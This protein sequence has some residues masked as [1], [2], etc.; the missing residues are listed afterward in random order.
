M[1][2]KTLTIMFIDVQGYT[3]LTAQKKRHEQQLFVTE[4]RE[5]VEKHVQAK[6]GK[7]TK[8][9]GDGFLVTFESPTD[10]ISCGI[11]LQKEISLR[12]KNVRNSENLISF[13]IGMSTGEVNVDDTGD[14]FGDVVNIAARI[15]KFAEPNEVFISESTYLAM[16]AAEI[17]ALDLGPQ[18]FKN[19]VREV[20]V[21]KVLKDAGQ[22]HSAFVL[23]K[24]KDRQLLNVL[25]VVLAL[26]FIGVLIST[27]GLGRQKQTRAVEG[28]LPENKTVVVPEHEEASGSVVGS[29]RR[30]ELRKPLLPEQPSGPGMVENAQPG[31][32]PFP[33]ADNYEQKPLMQ[34]NAPYAT[35]Q[36]SGGFNQPQPLLQRNMPPRMQKLK[37]GMLDS[38]RR[39]PC[40]DGV[41]DQFERN[42][43]NLCPQDC[44]K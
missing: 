43:P 3:L 27:L 24:S 6:S 14:V 8:A 7:L 13:R 42:N 5:F 28:I 34:Q 38:Q 39:H 37:Q 2:N 41:C 26:G 15:Q 1:L 21:F 19:V 20:R 36:E 18:R 22:E 35:S 44:P 32:Q 25:C 12:N 17:K 31:A 40:G 29:E 11:D 16:N 10:A 30:E 9:M 23:A 33:R 4:L